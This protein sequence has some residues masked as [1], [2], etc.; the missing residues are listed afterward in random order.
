MGGALQSQPA[1]DQWPQMRR[2]ARPSP[3]GS[4]SYSEASPTPAPFHRAAA[5]AAEEFKFKDSRWPQAH[6]QQELL[7]RALAES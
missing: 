3:C 1:R 6:I 5:E 2:R 7:R 4:P